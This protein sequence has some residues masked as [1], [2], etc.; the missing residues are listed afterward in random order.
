MTHSYRVLVIEDDPDP[1]TFL[2]LVLLRTPSGRPLRCPPSV[3]A[4]VRAIPN[5]VTGVNRELAPKSVLGAVRPV[6]L[7]V[8]APDRLAL[9][10][11][12]FGDAGCSVLAV[13]CAEQ[14]L[15]LFPAA[16]PD[17]LVLPQASSGI[18][19]GEFDRLRSRHPNCRVV[20]TTVID[21]GITQSAGPPNPQTQV[22]D[23][24]S[25]IKKKPTS[26]Q[27]G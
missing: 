27:L 16:R 20:V 24:R 3:R 14:A 8:D 4:L 18:D 19:D 5:P 12:Y 25:Q 9:L 23:R 15:T 21:P 17:L 6:T 2:R 26:A 7:I 22:A 1:V 11:A 13:G 10:T